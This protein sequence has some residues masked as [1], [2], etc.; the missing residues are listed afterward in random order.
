MKKE[1]NYETRWD[2]RAPKAK[3]AS[4][5]VLRKRTNMIQYKY[6]T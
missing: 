4:M 5:L 3:H 2:L 6:G 1:S